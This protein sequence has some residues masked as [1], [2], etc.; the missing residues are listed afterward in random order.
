MKKQSN[1]EVFYDPRMSADSG[2][3]SPSAAKPDLVVADW[4]DR[5]LPIDL[6]PFVPVSPT[7]IQLAHDI[8]YVADVLN[9][10]CDHGHL[11]TDS[12][13]GSRI[14]DQE[15]RPNRFTIG[16]YQLFPANGRSIGDDTIASRCLLV[17]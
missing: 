14:L 9:L 6:V 2:G 11:A 8:N 3:Y 7:T 5:G 16:K 13:L 10:D 4:V 12:T 15:S 17:G 1:L